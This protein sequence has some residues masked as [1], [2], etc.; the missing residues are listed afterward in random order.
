M[1]AHHKIAALRHLIGEL[2]VALAQRQLIHIGLVEHLSIDAHDT[3]GVDGDDIARPADDALEQQLVLPVKATQVA[4]LPIVRFYQQDH[5]PVLQGGVHAVARHLQHRQQQRGQ[6]HRNGRHHDQG[7]HRTAQHPPE[8]PP[9]GQALPF[10]IHP[11]QSLGVL[12]RFLLPERVDDV[13]QLRAA[14][15]PQFPL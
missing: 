2:D 8:T 9:F 10:R 6:Q 3:F 4:R 11:P 13:D 14:H 1:V 5:V 15:P 12:R 7:A